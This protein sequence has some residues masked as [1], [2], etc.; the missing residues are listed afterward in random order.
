MNF[1][2][3]SF[4]HILGEHLLNT[5]ISNVDLLFQ[6]KEKL[7]NSLKEGS[8]IEGLDSNTASTMELEELRHERDTQREEIQKLMGQIQQMRTELQV[9]MCDDVHMYL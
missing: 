7:I 9:A 3:K 5:A 2:A 8:G 1:R 6:S 4:W